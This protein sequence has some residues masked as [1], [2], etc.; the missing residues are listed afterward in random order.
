LNDCD[1]RTSEIIRSRNEVR[2]LSASDRSLV[3]TQ[4]DLSWQQ[5]LEVL[6]DGVA[7]VDGRGVIRH[8]NDR[9][10]V[11]T[12]YTVDEIVGQKVEFLIPQ[13][14]RKSHASGRDGFMHNPSSREMGSDMDLKLIRKDRSELA[15]DVSLAPLLFEGEQW[16]AALIRDESVRWAAETV[17]AQDELRFRLAFE[18]NMAP[19]VFTDLEDKAIAVNDAFCEMLGFTRE[20]IL[21]GGS[22]PFTRLEDVGITENSHQCMAQGGPDQV[23]YI[24]RYT[25]KDGRVIVVEVSR[26]RASDTAG[27][28]L[29]YVISE[30]DITERV[31]R[32]HLLRLLAD[33][34]K[35]A[36]HAVDEVEFRQEL[37]NVLVDRGGCALAWIGITS[38]DDAGGVEIMCAAGA[39]DYLHQ[40]MDS[41]WESREMRSGPTWTALQTG[42]SQV[43]NDLAH[44]SVSGAWGERAAQFGFGSMVAIPDRL[45]E[46]RAALV[47]YHRDVFSFDEITV[48]GLEDV[49][50]EAELAITHI[51]A[52]QGTS[53]ALEE[54]VTAIENLRE[55]ELALIES[56]QR[57]RLAFESNMA[58]MIFSDLEDK[59]V[60]VNDAFCQMVGFTREELL[61]HDSV[62]FTHPQDVG[63]TEGTHLR[64]VSDNVDQVRYTKRYLRKDGRIV[65]S[66]VSRSAARDASGKTLYFIAS[67]RDVTEER[68][69][70][71]QLSHLA[72]HDPLTGLANRVLFDD[73]LAQAHA[74]IAR[75][76]GMG[77][78]LLMDLDDFKGVNDSHGHLIGDQLLVGIA[79]RL[80][81]VTRSSDALCRFG[82]DEFLYLAEG[83]SSAG[84]AEDVANRLLEVLSE[85]FVFGG[86]NLEQRASIGVVIWDSTSRDST[87]FV[88]NA[89]VA[90]NEA[91]RAQR[92]H[93]AVFT[94]DM[95]QQVVSSFVL[96]QELRRALH[97][98]EISMHYQPIVNLA[99]TEVMGFEA[100]MRWHHPERG[101]VSP[102]VFIPLAE[103]SDFILELGDFALR[104][105]VAAAVSCVQVGSPVEP[106]YVTVNISAL[107]FHD[108]DLVPMIEQTLLHSGLAPERLI[109]EITESV[110]LRNVA[111]TLTV[112][113][114][115]DGLG[116]GIALDDFG[117][118]FSSLS[119][120]T[121]LHPRIIK[122]DKSFVSPTHDSHENYTLLET[123]ITLG[124]KLNM[125][126][127]A[128][129]IETPGQLEQ[130]RLLNC[131]LGQGYLFSPAVPASEVAAM[132]GGA[133]GN[134]G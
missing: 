6:P 84:E 81:L 110:A 11:I 17:R 116:I 25:H 82:G 48:N 37:C 52:I 133:P 96:A 86:L 65:F 130:L 59:A 61:G 75:Q 14:Q 127:L 27:N 111:L 69:L 100:L 34:N 45:G 38:T 117:T 94:R 32:D 55:T 35:L 114:R 120:L 128:E 112:I 129:G 80:E 72:L 29:Y 47:I 99:T 76:G 7:L 36:V 24:K 12:G 90:L 15:I 66:E 83:L 108:P 51:R 33:V 87:E 98:G 74:R 49:V 105:A 122:I 107:Q 89:D 85:P 119:Y 134:W 132:L 97:A 126:L 70:T 41:W 42:V 19:M 31:R 8:A 95:H 16:V 121:R 88:Q 54:T 21:G 13:R 56:E 101:W 39:S 123:I 53:V 1:E 124:T 103:Q 40:E 23:R 62:Q 18:D 113:E 9:L 102:A 58:P 2:R 43:V 68:A 30:R 5:L 50:R 118:G 71:A 92:G 63:I 67:E 64:L 44:H 78:V 125:T 91:K 28:P 20:E 22:K 73:R 46:R 79:R 104:E 77:A 131:H 60:A 106:P 10:A 4:Q 93:F 26:A 109:L 57:F 115:L 3:L